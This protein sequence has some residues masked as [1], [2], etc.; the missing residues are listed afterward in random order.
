[1]GQWWG[2]RKNGNL[3]E[4]LF[5]TLQV[6]NIAVVFKNV[7][8]SRLRDPGPQL[9]A[10]KKNMAEESDF[11][12][13]YDQPGEFSEELRKHLARWLR[14]HEKGADGTARDDLAAPSSLTA[15]RPPARPKA[16]PPVFC[17]WIEET[18]RLL[19]AG[20][21]EIATYSDALFCA[22][23]A[24]AS[25][26][27]D[28]EGAEAKYALGLCQLVFNKPADALATFSEIAT[29]FASSSDTDGPK[30]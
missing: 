8:E 27:S 14:D 18:Y 22:R 19:E 16:P 9:L 11:F 10:H 21:A 4:E 23:K 3:A 12:K 29:D 28:L 5:K 7:D 15:V 26:A 30:G 25:S 20:A 1:M 17:Y 24:L 13:S 2:P 6:R